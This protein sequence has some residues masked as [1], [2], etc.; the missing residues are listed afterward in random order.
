MIDVKTKEFW[1]ATTALGAASFLIFAN[2]YF[3]QPL[4]PL[5]TEEFAISEAAS[6][7]II[8]VALFVLGISFFIYTAL[9]D[10]FGR[11]SIIF[12]AMALGTI[13]TLAISAAPSF[14]WLLAA[15]IFQAAALAGIPVAAMAYISEEYKKKAMAAAIGIY[16]SCN[17]VGGMGGRVLSGVLTDLWNWRIAFVVMAVC[18]FLLFVL[19]YILLPKS[20]QFTARP[21]QLREVLHDNKDHLKNPVMRYAYIIGGL[22]FLVFI[23]I[24]NFIT[25]YLSGDPFFVSTAV[26]GLLFLT[27]GA[28]TVSSTLAGKAAQIWKQT[29]AVFIGV[30]LMVLAVVLTLIPSFPVI[31]GALLILSFGFFFAHS[32]SSAWVTRHADKAK[33]SASG[34]YLT[35][36]YLGGSLGSLYYGWLWPAFG[37]FGMVSGSLLVLVITYLCTKKLAVMEESEL[38]SSTIVRQSV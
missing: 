27:Y 12:I 29:S 1:K 15:R 19:V 23:G 11:R 32:T 7:L 17:S 37:W 9:S 10:A 30:A 31:I 6:S 36:Y 16:I 34:L 18:S 13:G 14:G 8:S 26:L 22:H 35:S 28:G 25:Y 33:A 2:M 5:F 21:F 24:F 4:L 38:H 3:P 20:Q